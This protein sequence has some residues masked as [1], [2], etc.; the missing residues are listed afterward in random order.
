MPVYAI[1]TP[2][3]HLTRD[4]KGQI[5]SEITRIHTT[6]T[7]APR[8]FVRVLFSE[9]AMGDSFTGGEPAPVARLQGIIRAGRS[10][11]DRARLLAELAAMFMQATGMAKRA[12][13]VEIFDHAA[14]D[15]IEGGY[16]LPEPGQEAAWEREHGYAQESVVSPTAG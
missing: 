10:Q 8:S 4:K 1:A 7:G 3:G 12:V 9:L 16:V 5:A 11:V 15:V 14:H 2:Q 6:I 13:L